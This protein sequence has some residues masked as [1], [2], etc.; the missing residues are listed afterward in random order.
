MDYFPLPARLVERFK[1]FERELVL[2]LHTFAL[3][4]IA[5]GAPQS[6]PFHQ[7]LDKIVLRPLL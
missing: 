2:L 6:R 1:H 5:Q 4:G 7:S 3:D